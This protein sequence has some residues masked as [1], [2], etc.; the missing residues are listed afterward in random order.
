MVYLTREVDHKQ[1]S[2]P[3]FDRERFLPSPLF[4]FIEKKPCSPLL[5]GFFIIVFSEALD[6]DRLDSNITPKHSV[7]GWELLHFLL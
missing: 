7:F 4:V 2:T 6:D 1:T 3:L 5:Q